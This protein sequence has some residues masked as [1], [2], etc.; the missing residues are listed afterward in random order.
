VRAHRRP[1]QV[2]PITPAGEL[3]AD[4]FIEMLTPSVK[5]AAVVHVSNVLGTVNPVRDLAKACRARGHSAA[6]RR[7]TGRAA[8]ADRRQALAD[9]Y[10]AT[11]HKLFG[12]TGTG[13]LWAGANGSNDAAVLRRRRDDQDVSFE[14]RRSPIRRTSS[15][16]AR[17]T[18]PASSVSA[19]R[20]TMSRR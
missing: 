7:L 12:P 3:I 16:P 17:R 15:R 2:A 1:A 18:S 9:F 19:P 20:S 6:R 8:P 13:M 11:G 10:R 4:R 5:L 14:R